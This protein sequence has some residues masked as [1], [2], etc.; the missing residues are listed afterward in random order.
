VSSVS[1]EASTL[2][3][4]SAHKATARRSERPSALQKKAVELL[5]MRQATKAPVPREAVE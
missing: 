1:S 4:P 2:L 5:E 3:R